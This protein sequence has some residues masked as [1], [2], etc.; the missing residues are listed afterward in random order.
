MN[1]SLKTYPIFDREAKRLAKRYK[2]LKQDITE[3]ARELLKAP[4]T[5]VDLGHGIHKVRMAI[6][7]KRKGKSRGARVIT[8]I[9]T[10]SQT[11][12][13]IGLHFIYDKSE[14]DNISNKELQDILKRN[15]I[16]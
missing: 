1:Y 6:K 15:G 16:L 12:K 13:Q 7:S 11:E 2:S 14:Q 8:V 9:I 10:L 3:L 4:E 5:G